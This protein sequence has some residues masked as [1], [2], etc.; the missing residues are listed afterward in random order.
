M[1]NIE[2]EILDLDNLTKINIVKK[3]LS[4]FELDYIDIDYTVVIWSEKKI[5]ATCSK[6][7]N[8]IK[9]VAISPEYSNLNILNKLLTI[10]IKQIVSEKY[11]ESLIITKREYKKI[12]E[13]LNFLSI[14]QNDMICFLT[15]RKDKFDKYVNYVKSSKQEADSAII[16]MNANPF[17]NGHKY[18]IETASNENE[19][20]YVV[21]VKED[22]SLF[23]YDERMLMLKKGTDHLK[24]IIILEG[25]KY[26]VSKT[27]FPSYFIASPDE[28]VKQQ[29]MLDIKMFS[30]IFIENL[31]IKKRY[32]GEEPLSNTTKI[33]NDTIKN[34]LSEI[35]IEVKIIKRLEENGEVVSASKVRELLLNEDLLSIKKITPSTT[36]EF[37]NNP[38][39]ISRAKNNVEKVIKKF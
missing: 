5:I 18:L 24:N 39:I 17:T 1:N 19:L 27:F 31:N 28:V 35:N 23:T 6:K 33:Y 16:V 37:I 7:N 32:L 11:D 25:S 9:C 2:I 12:F 34:V 30:K 22:V 26:I 20:V 38:E 15:N 4:N 3:Y 8:L 36:F 29:A 10:I 14:Y 13:D 21:L